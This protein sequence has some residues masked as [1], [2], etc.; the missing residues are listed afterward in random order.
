MFTFTRQ[1]RL[2]SKKSIEFLLKKNT[3]LVAHPFK[4]IWS[5]TTDPLLREA[6]VKDMP[7]VKF[8]VQMAISV[9]KRKFKRAVDRNRI[10]RLMRGAYRQNKNILYDFCH[11]RNENYMLLFIYIASNEIS[12][13]EMN[14]KIKLSLNRLI[15]E[16]SS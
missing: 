15:K 10:K 13:L 5:K 14:D 1:E 11:Q 16:I 3:S 8:P 7:T 2:R 12:F 9:P 4:I 6:P